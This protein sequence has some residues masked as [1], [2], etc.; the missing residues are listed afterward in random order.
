LGFTVIGQYKKSDILKLQLP[1]QIHEQ[2]NSTYRF[3]TFL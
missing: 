1:V 2:I 3:S